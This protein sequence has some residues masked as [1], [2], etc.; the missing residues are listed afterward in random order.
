MNTP[1]LTPIKR[2]NRN[3]CFQTSTLATK[4]QVTEATEQKLTKNQDLEVKVQPEDNKC[5][6]W[7][8]NNVNNFFKIAIFATILSRK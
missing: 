5:F 1:R 2:A 8:A 4:I 6:S 7:L 3:E